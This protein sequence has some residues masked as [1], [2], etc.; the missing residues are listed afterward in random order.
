MTNTTKTSRRS[1]YLPADLTPFL[2]ERGLLKLVLDA[3]QIVDP[4]RFVVEE[5]SHPVFRPQMMLTLL[6]YCYSA[7]IYGSPDIEWALRHDKTVRY[8]CARTYPDWQT[9]RRFRRQ[10]RDLLQQTLA[11][12][13]KQTWALK[14]DEGEA[15]YIGYD[16]FE[17]ELNSEVNAAVQER[18]D[19][20]ALLDGVE[21]E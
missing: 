17:L 4:A 6:T 11:Y 16:W 3:V 14:F 13:F 1:C 18:L 20:A 7:K 2:G 5:R 10:H 8:I 15:D 12:V 21:S 19:L 9:F